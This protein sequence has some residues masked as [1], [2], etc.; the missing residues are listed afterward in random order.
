MISFPD[1]PGTK[2]IFEDR[3][4]QQWIINWTKAKCFFRL[5][6]KNEFIIYVLNLI[7]FRGIMVQLNSKVNRV[8]KDGETYT[9]EVTG[10][11]GDQKLSGDCVMLAAGR[12]PNVEGAGLDKIGVNVEKSGIGVNEYLY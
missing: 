12:V 5:I 10:P 1:D 8:L 9:V 11:Q 3:T 4:N 6:M 7:P 2:V